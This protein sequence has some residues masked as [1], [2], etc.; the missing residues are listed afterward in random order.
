MN[1]KEWKIGRDGRGRRLGSGA[2][3]FG[4]WEHGIAKTDALLFHPVEQAARPDKFRRQDAQSQHDGEPTRTGGDNHED[5][6][7]KQS[8]PEENLQEALRL[9]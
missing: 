3:G 6:Q 2:A 1:L 4:A 9:L 5:P 7:S 8:E